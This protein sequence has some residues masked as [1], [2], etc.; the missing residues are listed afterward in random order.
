MEDGGDYGEGHDEDGGEDGGSRQSW[1]SM[2]GETGLI[3]CPVM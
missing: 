1:T 2:K 3:S